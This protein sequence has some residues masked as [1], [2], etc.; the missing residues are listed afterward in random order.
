MGYT[1]TFE[2]SFKLDRALA[3]EHAAFLRAFNETRRMDR[4][5]AQL[6]PDPIRDAA[7]LPASDAHYFV[8]GGGSYGQDH[9]PSIRNY[10]EPPHGQPGLWCK[11][12]P[13]ETG[14]AIEWDGA[15]KFYDY[16]DW[17]RYLIANFIQ[18]W[19]YK[20]N[21]EVAWEGEE[22]GDVGKLIVKDNAVEV[23]EGQAH[24]MI[25]ERAA[26]PSPAPEGDDDG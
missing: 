7:G 17:L 22:Q 9:D 3:P 26:S 2:G 16:V 13:N 23:L 24:A 18:P 25:D 8:S 6:P 5:P 14:D 11:W 12:A 4:D 21:G 1:T 20:L 19:G 15:E 10:N